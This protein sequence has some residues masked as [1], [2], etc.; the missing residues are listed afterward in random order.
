[1]NPCTVTW[2]ASGHAV[3]Y[4]AGA[5]HAFSEELKCPHCE[6]PECKISKA[7]GKSVFDI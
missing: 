3:M 2:V 5:A 7:V 6:G 1:M 4:Y